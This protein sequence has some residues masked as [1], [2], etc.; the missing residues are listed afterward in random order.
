MREQADEH[1]HA[2]GGLAEHQPQDRAERDVERV[3]GRRRVGLERRRDAVEQLAAPDQV[4]VG[5]VVGIG[6]RDR[7]DEHGDGHRDDGGRAL[8]RP[9]EAAAGHG[10]ARH[11]DRLAAM[12]VHR[13][14]LVRRPARAAT[15]GAHR[16]R[17]AE[18][19]QRPRH[20]VLE[21]RRVEPRVEHERGE[22]GRDRGPDGD[23]ARAAQQAPEGE[24]EQRD[25]GGEADHALLGGDRDRDR[26]RG[27]R[28]LA[29]GRSARGARYSAWKLPE[30]QPASG[31]SR[32][33]ASAA[34]HQVDA[35]DVA[36]SSE[37]SLNSSRSALGNANTSTAATTTATTVGTSTHLAAEAQPRDA[38]TARA[39]AR[40][41]STARAS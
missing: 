7:P 12:P 18:R 11:D 29:A 31:R 14:R 6:A 15:T 28:R 32:A 13:R 26:V 3:L 27:R 37:R 23:A 20:R 10:R 36:R 17:R 25:V 5:V 16:E 9:R 41:S 34:A 38:R 1:Q 30:P 35:P 19:E 39:A 21:E 8:D 22:A 2:I 24:H 40:R 4:E 33:S